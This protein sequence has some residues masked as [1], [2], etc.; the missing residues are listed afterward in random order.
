MSKAITYR[1]TFGISDEAAGKARDHAAAKA[2]EYDG[3][4]AFHVVEL[5]PFVYKT[6]ESDQAGTVYVVDTA[7]LDCM[8]A[9]E[10]E[11]VNHITTC[12]IDP[13]D[14]DLQQQE[15]LPGVGVINVDAL[16]EGDEV[17]NFGRVLKL[18]KNGVFVTAKFSVL[19]WSLASATAEPVSEE[20][21]W[22][23]SEELHVKRA[24]GG[25]DR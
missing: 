14:P 13:N 11:D 6:K 17:L 5:G 2:S 23:V 1:R 4:K 16:A 9:A 12:G 21:T 19:R 7:E 25:H 20:R 15:R 3:H 8:Q 22:H 18:Y 24:E 10:G